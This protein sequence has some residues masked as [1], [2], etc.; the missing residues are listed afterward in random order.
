MMEGD[1]PPVGLG[2]GRGNSGGTGLALSNANEKISIPE[3]SKKI[4]P[5][6][7]GLLTKDQLVH[8]LE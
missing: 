4:S 3:Q 2:I 1:E 6:G 7:P 8:R 5:I